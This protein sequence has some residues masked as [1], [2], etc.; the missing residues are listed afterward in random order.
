MND[1]F[2]QLVARISMQVWSRRGVAG[3]REQL[4][5]KT[6]ADKKQFTVKTV[7][8]INLSSVRNDGQPWTEGIDELERK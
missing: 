1:V 2:N 4:T 3:G 7:V 5:F 8:S 6:T